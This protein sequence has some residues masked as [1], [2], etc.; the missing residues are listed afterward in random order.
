MKARPT[1]F[2]TGKKKSLVPGLKSAESEQTQF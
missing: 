1:I 2:L